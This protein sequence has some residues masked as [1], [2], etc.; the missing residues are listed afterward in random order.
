MTEPVYTSRSSIRQ[1]GALHRRA[2]LEAGPEVDMGV[3]GAIKQLFKLDP[4]RELPLPVDYIVA[5]TG[6]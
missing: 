2:Q 3:H 5:A 4:A 1:G 6:G